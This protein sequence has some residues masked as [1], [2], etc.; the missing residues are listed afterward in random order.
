MPTA[1]AKGR[2]RW[3]PGS[4]PTRIA[5][6]SCSNTTDGMLHCG[7]LRRLPGDECVRDELGEDGVELDRHAGGA[8]DTPVEALS[9]ASAADLTHVRH[10]S[11]KVVERGPERESLVT[12]RG[13]Q[14]C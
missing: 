4:P 5:R 1:K 10:E 14:P 6:R 13:P 3:R 8:Q 7:I 2:C 11:R 9:I 12:S